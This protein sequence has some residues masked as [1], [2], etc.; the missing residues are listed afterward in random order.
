MQDDASPLIQ[1]EANNLILRN[2]VEMEQSIK[3]NHCTEY[4]VQLN[5]NPT[6]CVLLQRTDGL[7]HLIDTSKE[8]AATTDDDL[9]P[10]LIETIP[11]MNPIA[12]RECI[13][14]GPFTLRNI[15]WSD[16]TSLD[17]MKPSEATLLLDRNMKEMLRVYEEIQAKLKTQ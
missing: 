11:Q 6:N 1:Q 16:L 9:P 2:A 14:G 15:K 3:A 13:H 17:D 12:S 10:L 8:K 4:T 7:I 5:R